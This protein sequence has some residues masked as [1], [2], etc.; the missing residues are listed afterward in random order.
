MTLSIPLIGLVDEDVAN[1]TEDEEIKA[2]V[3]EVVHMVADL[4]SFRTNLASRHIHNGHGSSSSFNGY[5]ALNPSD[6]SSAFNTMQLNYIDPN[7]V[8][9]TGAEQHVTVICD[10]QLFFSGKI[11]RTIPREGSGA[12]SQKTV[13][14]RV[15][16]ESVIKETK[17][18]SLGFS[19][20]DLTTGRLLSRH[21]STGTLYPMTQPELPSQACFLATT[22][23]HWHER[24]GHP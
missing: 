8:T 19:L 17:S 3:P 23:L 6:L 24:L 16:Y 4:G 22:F 2:E 1:H 11:S 10:F 20:K 9:D 14:A 15:V 13:Q 5:D 21:N 7:L 18:R 12:R